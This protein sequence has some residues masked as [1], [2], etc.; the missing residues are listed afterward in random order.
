MRSEPKKDRHEVERVSLRTRR[1]VALS[2]EKEEPMTRQSFKD[3]C[4]INK[5][6]ERYEK[7]GVLEHVKYMQDLDRQ[8]G[9]FMDAPTYHEACNQMIDANNAFMLLPSKLRKRFDNDPGKF[10]D[11]AQDPENEREMRKLGLLPAKR[12]ESI[13]ATEGS[14][15]PG[16]PGETKEET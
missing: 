9:D 7:T 12:P 6:M 5:I 4:D 2:F 16:K 13:N 15:E 11:F 14:I 3:E 8:Y 1:R 10:L